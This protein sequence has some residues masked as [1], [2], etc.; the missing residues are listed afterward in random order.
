MEVISFS[1]ILSIEQIHYDFWKMFFPFWTTD[2]INNRT[3]IFLKKKE[4]KIIEDDTW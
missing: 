2:E 1:S 4:R 3:D